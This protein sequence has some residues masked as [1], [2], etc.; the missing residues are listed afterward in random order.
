MRPVAT[1][2]TASSDHIRM[3]ARPMS[4]A[5]REV[6]DQQLVPRHARPCAGHPRLSIVATSKTWMAGSRPAMTAFVGSKSIAAR[7][8]ADRFL[9][10]ILPAIDGNRRAG[11][12]A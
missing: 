1:V 12:E 10:Q 2:M 4:V 8:D 11:D 5:V 9:R 3:A 7:V 6:M